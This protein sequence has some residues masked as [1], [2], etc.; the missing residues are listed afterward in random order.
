MAL[1]SVKITPGVNREGTNLANESTWWSSDKVRFRSGYPEKIGGWTSFLSNTYLGVCRALF[2]WVSQEGINILAVGT[3]LK[4]YMEQGYKLYD[5]TP[6]RATVTLANNPFTTTAASA[7]VIVTDVAHGATDSAFVT[8]SGASAVGGLTLN[9]E[10]IISYIDADTYSIVASAPASSTATGGGASV[11]AEYL[12][13]PGLPIAV[14]GTGWGAGAWSRGTWGSSS[15]VSITTQMRL[16]AQ[17]NYGEDLV[18]CV[19]DGAIYYWAQTVASVSV[20]RAV[21]L[22]TLPFASDVPVVASDIF[23]SDERHVVALGCNPLGTLTQDPMF[24]RWTDTESAANWT[25][26]S[27]N[28]AGGQ[29]LV[30]GSH[31][32]G[33]LKTKQEVLLWTDSALIS[34]R[35]TG[36][37][38][39]YGFT[40]V[41]TNISIASPNAM[42]AVS[43]TVFWMGQDKF[44]TYTGQVDTLPCTLKGYIFGD[45]NSAQRQ[46]ITCGTNE[47][48]N[49]VWW[50]YPSSGSSYNDRYVI[51]NYL[52][53]IWYYGELARTAWVDSPLRAFPMAASGGKLYFHE[54]GVND[55][56]TNPPQAFS[57]SIETANFDIGDGDHVMFVKRMIPDVTFD[58]STAAIPAVSMTVEVR[59]FPGSVYTKTTASG[60]SRS[61]NV[62]VEVF[63][64]Q[65]WIRLRGRQC[66]FRI[67]SSMLGVQWQL[68]AVRL[69]IIPDGRR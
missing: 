6:I 67:S 48:F 41:A 21:E 16:W 51:Y 29:K 14:S 53:R 43:N 42:I 8:F 24:V 58:G 68:G 54:N 55:G 9:G 28:T 19:R 35:F 22:N 18:F 5:I 44:Y 27:E 39:T 69:D 50:F 25:P 62:P 32:I 59:N 65:V 52:E 45:L 7:E 38:Y 40:P 33:H 37:P 2:N 60:V 3:H 1:Q 11:S 20:A 64:E 66:A 12:I 61:T 15:L 30:N 34:M 10:Y 36:P 57:A 47:G 4:Y 46:Q 49:E 63:T 13:N 56:S 17:D 31:L 26:T 23:V